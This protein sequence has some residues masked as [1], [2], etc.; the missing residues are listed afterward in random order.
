ML[1][2]N[3]IG[4]YQNYRLTC[5]LNNINFFNHAISSNNLPSRIT[6]LWIFIKASAALPFSALGRVMACIYVIPVN[7]IKIV[8]PVEFNKK[9]YL[10]IEIRNEF[11]HLISCFA[12]Q[13][14]RIGSSMVGILS[15]KISLNGWRVAERI[16]A[17]CWHKKANCK[18]QL[19]AL[20]EEGQ[21]QDNDQPAREPIR[22]PIK[23][24]SAHLYLGTQRVNAIGQ[25]L[26]LDFLTNQYNYSYT[27]PIGEDRN[28]LSFGHPHQESIVW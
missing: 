19:L 25:Q 11:L 9:K 3:G 14:L 7:L 5:K 20:Q 24:F 4:C 15:P 12:I 27:P 18:S 23:L 17:Y 2:T 16:D 28:V 22:L 1:S 10:L 6:H 8:I 26:G 13:F 21:V